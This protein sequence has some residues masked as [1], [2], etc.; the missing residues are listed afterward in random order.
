MRGAICYYS[1]TGNTALACRY[2]ARRSPVEF[3]L[4]DV[5][6]GGDIDPGA[7][8]V[9]GF[10]APTDFWGIPRTFEAFIEGLPRQEHKP[11]FLL[12]TFGAISGKTLRALEQAVSARGFAAVAGHSLRM[13]EAYPPMIARRL[14]AASSPS[15]RRLA[16]F[17]SFIS[18]LAG[19]L[20]S[21]EEGGRIEAREL[22]LGA[23]NS[24]LPTYPRTKARD[25]MG[26][27][28][29][30]PS[31]C[32]ECGTCERGCPYGAIRLGPKPIFDMAKCYGCWRCYNRCPQG[33]IHTRAFPGRPVYRGPGEVLKGK[34]ET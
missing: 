33:A 22:R 20:A 19:L 4:I 28:T 29:V 5:T 10:A 2:V 1:G 15:P 34:L 24:I 14:D 7:Y 17:D 3:D 8:D 23:L 27:K 18:R 16:G 25:D 11:A 32:K 12:N 30:D 9:V 21:V 13:P 6:M 26:A 31:A